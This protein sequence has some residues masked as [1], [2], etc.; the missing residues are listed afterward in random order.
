MAEKY[1]FMKNFDKNNDR[2]KT[3]ISKYIDDYLNGIRSKEG[4]II[5]GETPP[6][7]SLAGADTSLKLVIPNEQINHIIDK[8]I[9]RRSNYERLSKDNVLDLYN[10]LINPICLFIGSEKDSCVVITDFKNQDGLNIQVPIF[11]DISKKFIKVNDIATQYPNRTINEYVVKE[12][13]KHNLIAINNKKLENL[14]RSIGLLLPVEHTSNSSDFNI[15]Y[16]I[17]FV[18]SYDDSIIHN[19]DNVK[20]MEINNLENRYFK[21]NTDN[22]FFKPTFRANYLELNNACKELG[23]G[24]ALQYFTEGERIS[25]VRVGEYLWKIE[26]FKYDKDREQLQNK[27][28]ELKTKEIDNKLKE[29]KKMLNDK[30]NVLRISID[31]EKAKDSDTFNSLVAKELKKRSVDYAYDHYFKLRSKEYDLQIDVHT[32]AGDRTEFIESFKTIENK[33]NN[34]SE[35]KSMLNVKEEIKKNALEFLKESKFTFED[36]YGISIDQKIVGYYEETDREDLVYRVCNRMK[37]DALDE[38]SMLDKYYSGVSGVTI[39]NVYDTFYKDCHDVYEAMYTESKENL[40]KIR[41]EIKEQIKEAINDFEGKTDDEKM[42][43]FYSYYK[44]IYEKQHCYSEEKGVGYNF[45]KD[46]NGACLIYYEEFRKFYNYEKEKSSLDF[47][48]YEEFRNY[49]DNI[50]P[51][52]DEKLYNTYLKDVNDICN[53]M[54]NE[55]FTRIKENSIYAEAIAKAEAETGNDTLKEDSAQ[56][57]SDMIKEGRESST[58]DKDKGKDKP[59]TGNE[60]R[61]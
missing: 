46:G 5:L 4:H 18:N 47:K 29:I 41:E 6:V 33:E 44:D 50:V 60:G 31:W 39:E 25:K 14:L 2:F 37:I 56:I 28:I 26:M 43:N 3:E 40:S 51:V 57:I 36:K 38:E 20:Y 23:W 19:L 21:F 7:L 32:K 54:Y 10:S 12:I 27:L 24:D 13:M 45:A 58:N 8:H 22:K 55:A 35:V 17:K 49:K 1:D 59:S 48:T 34:D 30:Q 42:L 52:E 15:P 11:F 53:E 16:N 9:T 61:D